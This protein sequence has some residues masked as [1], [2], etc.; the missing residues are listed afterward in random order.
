MTNFFF[1]PCCQGYLTSNEINNNEL[2]V[3]VEKIKDKKNKLNSN[4]VR[5]LYSNRSIWPLGGRSKYMPTLG[6]RWEETSIFKGI[7]ITLKIDFSSPTANT[8]IIPELGN[9]AHAMKSIID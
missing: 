4:H 6:H 5:Q 2:I 1:L 8:D 9:V 3:N 7:S